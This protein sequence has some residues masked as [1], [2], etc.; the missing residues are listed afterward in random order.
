MVRDLHGGVVYWILLFIPWT[1]SLSIYGVARL[2]L[3]DHLIL[4]ENFIH[5]GQ[6]L[7]LFLEGTL[8]EDSCLL[9]LGDGPTTLHHSLGPTSLGNYSNITCQIGLPRNAP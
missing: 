3:V 1:W 2:F 4:G 5:I 7:L 8:V 6:A 9:V